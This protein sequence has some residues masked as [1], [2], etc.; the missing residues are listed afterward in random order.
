MEEVQKLLN[1]KHKITLFSDPKNSKWTSRNR[2]FIDLESIILQRIKQRKLAK[3]IDSKNFDLCFVSHDRHSQAPWILRFLK[4]PTVFLCQ[5]PTRALFEEFLKIDPSL[6]LPNR[7]YEKINRQVR[8][9]I[10]I[11]SAK[12][13]TV[14]VA[15][16]YFSVESIFRSY[17]VNAIPVHLGVDPKEYFPKK[18]AKKNQ[19]LVI[20]NNEPQK[21]LKLSIE[22]VSLVDKKIR[23][24]LVIASPRKN[25]MKPIV[26]FAKKK[27]VDIKLLLSLS[28]KDLCTVYNQSRV[29]L[30]LAHL[31]PFGLS[32]V[33]SMACGTPV[34]A[35]CEGGFRETVTHKKTGLLTERNPQKIADSISM[36]LSNSELQSEMGKNG[37]EAVKKFFTWE[38][39]VSKLEKIFYET[40]K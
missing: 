32:V 29:T 20:G 27:G 33:E 6:P 18:I 26:N 19:L 7:I 8:K 14:T 28:Q 5:E 3:H 10:E 1:K 34:I 13:A 40:K 9:N 4:T 36:L 11:V 31:E 37:V 17:G 21:D 25:S 2:L 15:N 39:T 16:S 35:V 23:P 24:V 12:K 38:K 30:A 22:A